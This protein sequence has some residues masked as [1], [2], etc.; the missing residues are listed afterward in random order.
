MSKR[1]DHP[2]LYGTVASVLA[3]VICALLAFLV[4]GLYRWALDAGSAAWKFLT[5]AGGTPRWVLIVLAA[6]AAPTVYRALRLLLPAKS[7][8]PTVRPA[9]FTDYTED[10][11]FGVVWR[12]AYQQGKLLPPAGFCPTCDTQLVYSEPYR[13]I[14]VSLVCEHCHKTVYDG[15]GGLED[16]L[17][18]VARQ[19]ERKLRSGEWQRMVENKPGSL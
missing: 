14:S 1:G 17:N 12:W 7:A 3:T 15:E 16:A 6:V 5:A 10:T 13:G 9:R 11:F 4:P 18:R 2:I 8:G 19:I